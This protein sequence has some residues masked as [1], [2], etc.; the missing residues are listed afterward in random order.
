MANPSLSGKVCLITG[1]NSGIGFIT[2][3]ELAKMGAT[4]LMVARDKQKGEAALAE[5]K[6]KSGSQAV[7]LLLADFT[8]LQSVRELAAEVKRR[9]PKLHVLV[10]N[11]GTSLSKRELTQDGFEMMFG[12]NHL[13]HFLLTNLLLDALKAGAPSRIVNV[14]SSAEK[15]GRMDFDD[16]QA[17]KKFSFLS[18]YSQSKLAN[19]LFTYELARRLEGTGVT[20]NALHPGVVRTNLGSQNTGLFKVL[21][22]VMKP[23]ILSPEQ[24]AETQIYAASAPELEGVTGKYFIKKKQAQ[25]SKQSYDAAAAKRL[26]EVSEKLT[27]SA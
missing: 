21:L 6:A 15:Q 26:W 20:V 10:N 7:E 8:S 19:L 27:G 24:G 1:A 14:S 9:Y 22:A 23:F 12:V 25:S 16:L 13:A 3:L 4:V 17:E 5:V 11:A 18:N 2:A